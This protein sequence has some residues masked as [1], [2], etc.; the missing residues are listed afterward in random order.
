MKVLQQLSLDPK[1]KGC[2]FLVLQRKQVFQPAA[3][4]NCCFHVYGDSRKHLPGYEQHQKS[5]QFLTVNGISKSWDLEMCKVLAS[6]SLPWDSGMPACCWKVNVFISKAELSCR[7][8]YTNG[9]EVWPTQWDPVQCICDTE[10]ACILGSRLG[11]DLH[12]LKGL[13]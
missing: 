9:Q 4:S 3:E 7:A 11:A 13:T 12:R 1:D 6:S 10:V 2:T 5:L 8:A